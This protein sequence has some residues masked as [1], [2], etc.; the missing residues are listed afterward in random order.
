[1]TLVEER[2]ATGQPTN[3]PAPP[4]AEARIAPRTTTIGDVSELAGSA[5]SGLCLAWLVYE[6]L[7]PLGGLVGFVLAWYAATIAIYALVV[8]HEH[9]RI[10]GR[11]RIAGMVITTSGALLIASLTLVVGYTVVKGIGAL[12]PQFFTQTQEFV[13]PL[14]P[15]TEGGGAH[16]IVGT[17]EQVGLACLMSVPV[18]VL[19]ALF[20]NEVGGRMA[21]PVRTI[22]DAMSGIPSILT[23][24]FIFATLIFSHTLKFSGFVA[25]LALSILMIPT[26]TRT[27]EV[28]LRLVPGGLREASLALGGTEWRTVRHVVLP[29]ARSGLATAVILSMARVIGETA[30]LLLTAGGAYVMN[31]N[32]F[33][34]L[35]DSL[36]LFVYRLRAFPQP[37]Q[38]QRMWT[39]ALVLLAIVLILF[40]IARLLGGQGP[41]HV[42]R[43]QR[44][45]LKRKGLL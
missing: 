35:Q 13:G 3:L 20:L 4:P 23:G 21:R 9:G 19:T 28:V 38:Q 2:T 25:A 1:M 7:T 27:A 34:G 26:V 37:A 30:P 17:L 22:V 8:R 33:S 16:A 15:A 5:L 6:R 14:S 18:G 43:F 44:R 24:L 40:V 39:G 12:R 10:A 11:D 41:G 32:P 42:G 29:T 31:A 45:R 36:P